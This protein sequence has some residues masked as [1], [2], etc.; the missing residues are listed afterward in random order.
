[1]EALQGQAKLSLFFV[2]GVVYFE[3]VTVKNMTYAIDSPCMKN[4]YANQR[5]A[6]ASMLADLIC[7]AFEKTKSIGALDIQSQQAPMKV[8][9]KAL[10]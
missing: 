8:F 5:V 3:K 9:G 1:M 10:P 2:G 6:K 7:T 4:I